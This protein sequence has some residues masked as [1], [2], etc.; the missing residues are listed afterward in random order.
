[1]K[2]VK[3]V[4]R[5]GLVEERFSV[6]GSPEEVEGEGRG[7]H[8]ADVA[9]G[10]GELRAGD[11]RDHRDECGKIRMPGALAER[12]RE[13]RGGHRGL[14]GGERETEQLHHD[15]ASRVVRCGEHALDERREVAPSNEELE[16]RRPRREDAAAA[17]REK[18]LQVF[19]SRRGD[20]VLARV[21]SAL[22]DF[23]RQ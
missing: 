4:G 10:C 13:R 9:E 22:D 15:K 18:H 17:R 7:D 5:R 11:A 20:V 3:D 2:R 12:S 6:L 8:E 19:A 16:R 1:M 21:A 14:L 23:A